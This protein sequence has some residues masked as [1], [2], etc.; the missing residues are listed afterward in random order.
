MLEDLKHIEKI[1]GLIIKHQQGNLDDTEYQE[2]MLWCN[3]SEDNYQFLMKLLDIDYV[4]SKIQE[5]SDVH[6]IKE[7]G[8]EKC[9]Q[10]LGL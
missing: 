1:A 6:A 3:I 5:L 8:W 2:L 10:S 4:R 7:A 9:C